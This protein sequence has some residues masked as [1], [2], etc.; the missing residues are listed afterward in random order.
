MKAYIAIAAL[1]YSL[2]SAVEILEDD[3]FEADIFDDDLLDDDDLLEDDE[4]PTV[5]YNG[6]NYT[7]HEEK[8]WWMDATELCKAEGGHLLSIRSDE[9]LAAILPLIPVH[10]NGRHKEIH[11]ALRK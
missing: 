8:L 7:F 11:I 10:A 2:T 9:E 5:Y 4:R 3:I 6:F 1:L